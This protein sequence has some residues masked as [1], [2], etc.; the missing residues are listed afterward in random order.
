MKVPDGVRDSFAVFR[1]RCEKHAA[2]LRA[3]SAIAGD[4]ATNGLLGGSLRWSS[5]DHQ[6]ANP[7]GHNSAKPRR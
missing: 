3:L 5:A 1:M 4:A 7:A 2:G 6:Q